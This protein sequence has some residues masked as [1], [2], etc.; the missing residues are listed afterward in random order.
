MKT[1]FCVPLINK[2]VEKEVLSCLN[3]T[4]WVTTGPKVNELE[5]GVYLNEHGQK[6]MKPSKYAFCS[7]PDYSSKGNWC[8]TN[9]QGSYK[10]CCPEGKTCL[11]ILVLHV[12]DGMKQMQEKI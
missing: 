11:V 1:P 8:Y 12:K 9:K 4:G 3:E 10:Y 2:D 5:K 6:I 7:N